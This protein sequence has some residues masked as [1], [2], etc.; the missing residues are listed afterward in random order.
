MGGPATHYGSCNFLLK[1]EN[2]VIEAT[3]NTSEFFKLN[4]N[5]GLCC[6][7]PLKNHLFLNTFNFN[8]DHGF[9]YLFT[10]VSNSKPK[11]FSM[12]TEQMMSLVELVS[13][14]FV[15]NFTLFLNAKAPYIRDPLL[16][17]HVCKI[18]YSG[19]Y[20]SRLNIIMALSYYCFLAYSKIEFLWTYL[21]NTAH[22]SMYKDQRQT[23]RYLWFLISTTTSKLMSES[24]VLGFKFKIKGKFTGRPGD[25]RKVF[26]FLCEKSSVADSKGKYEIH[27]L[28]PKNLNGATG[29]TITLLRASSN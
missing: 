28:Q 26:F 16:L 15:C 17:N 1:T 9:L 24:E 25:R 8:F 12:F 21:L 11:K 22:Q 5:I 7:K 13:S 19:H 6:K 2:S 14:L 3:N 23:Y 20:L 10:Q 27:Y 29:W 4:Q 18:A